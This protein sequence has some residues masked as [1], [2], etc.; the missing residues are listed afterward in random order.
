[1]QTKRPWKPRIGWRFLSTCLSVWV[2]SLLVREHPRA[3]GCLSERL[4]P[5]VSSFSRLFR[6]Q[7]NVKTQ[8]KQPF[9][10]GDCLVGWGLPEEGVGLEKFVPPL[11]S[12]RETNFILQAILPGCLKPL[13]GVR[14]ACANEVCAH[15]L[16]Q[17]WHHTCKLR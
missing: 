10:F 13:G 7:C 14:N 2:Q 5:L 4:T 15:F 11:E 6:Q 16:D 9:G 8:K 12:P 1:M 17:M 3:E